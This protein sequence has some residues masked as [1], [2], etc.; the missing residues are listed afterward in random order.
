[1]TEIT[2]IPGETTIVFLNQI[3]AQLGLD[4]AKLNS[5]YNALAPVSDGFLMPNTYKIPV[6][7]SE[8]H[9]AY[10]LVNSSKK[11]AKRDQQKNFW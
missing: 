10:Y 7:I 11:G 2:L 1:M 4:G 6:G 8:R 9:L 3:A 5:E